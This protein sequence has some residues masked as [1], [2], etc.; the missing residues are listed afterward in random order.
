MH[1]IE[2]IDFLQTQTDECSQGSAACGVGSG[3]AL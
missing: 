1:E 3:A 2:F